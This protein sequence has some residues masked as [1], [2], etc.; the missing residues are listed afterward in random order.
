MPL[1][2]LPVEGEVGL[3]G[4]VMRDSEKQLAGSLEASVV[5]VSP[6]A[7]H[8]ALPGFSYFFSAERGFQIVRSIADDSEAVEAVL[9]VLFIQLEFESSPTPSPQYRNGNQQH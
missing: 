2:S 9:Y 7:Y 5:L 8:M 6:S 3:A 4:S 1:I